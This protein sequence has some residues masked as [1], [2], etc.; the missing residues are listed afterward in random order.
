MLTVTRQRAFDDGELI[1]RKSPEGSENRGPAGR[2]GHPE[3]QPRRGHQRAAP[4]PP[5]VQQPTGAAGSAQTTGIRSRRRRRERAHPD[6]ARRPTGEATPAPLSFP[7][8]GFGTPRGPAHRLVRQ[9]R[10]GRHRRQRRLPHVPAGHPDAHSPGEAEP[11]PRRPR[12]R[13]SPPPS[14][15]AAR[16]PRPGMRRR[17]PRQPGRHHRATARPRRR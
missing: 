7:S 17:P 10:A 14:P 6:R 5:V 11:G 1:R 2:H 9:H 3:D 16:T 15:A 13:S 4:G 8:Y 12:S